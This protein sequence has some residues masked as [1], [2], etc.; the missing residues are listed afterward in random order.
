MDMNTEVFLGA[1]FHRKQWKK[2]PVKKS[3][4]IPQDYKKFF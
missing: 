2:K 4:Y 1:E 3:K